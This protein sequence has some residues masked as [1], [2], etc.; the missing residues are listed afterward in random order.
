[1]R[2]T[3]RLYSPRDFELR[4][5]QDLETTPVAIAQQTGFIFDLFYRDAIYD[6]RLGIDFLRRYTLSYLEA[7][8]QGARNLCDFGG[9]SFNDK[10]LNS[11]QAA[12]H[13]QVVFSQLPERFKSTFIPAFS[14]IA[15]LKPPSSTKEFST[16]IGEL[17]SGVLEFIE[18]EVE[19]KSTLEA[20]PITLRT[21]GFFRV[22]SELALKSTNPGNP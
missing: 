7:A 22:A 9:I 21:F 2:N 8:R 1:M 5:C 6:R 12:D 18:G 14:R 3:E 16:R 11:L 20:Y 13:A 10:D 4:I 15:N 19:P 17:K